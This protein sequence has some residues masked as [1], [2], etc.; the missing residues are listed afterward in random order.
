MVGK[1]LAATV[2]RRESMIEN[3]EEVTVCPHCGAVNRPFR[4]LCQQC[5]RLLRLPERARKRRWWQFWK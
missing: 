3:P 1:V 2:C 4:N 5:F